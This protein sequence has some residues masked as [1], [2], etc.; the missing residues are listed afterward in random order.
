MKILWKCTVS[1]EFRANHLKLSGN[2]SF[3]QNVHTKKLGQISI[4]CAV[5]ITT[6]NRTI[7]Y[8]NTFFIWILTRFPNFKL[9]LCYNSQCLKPVHYYY[10]QCCSFFLGIKFAYNVN[11]LAL[12][13]PLLFPL[14]HTKY[15]R[16]KYN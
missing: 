6:C 4:F 12:S 2:C 11:R 1:S 7:I 9:V 3:S 14:I 16:Y 5:A 13:K 10:Y 15:K 8:M